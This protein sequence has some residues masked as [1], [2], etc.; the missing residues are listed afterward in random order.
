[1]TASALVYAIADGK[2]FSNGRQLAAWLGLT[3]SQYNSGGKK[4]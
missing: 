1:M 2:K 4:G 3:P